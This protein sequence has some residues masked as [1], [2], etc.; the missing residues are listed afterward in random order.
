V[1]SAGSLDQWSNEDRAYR[2]RAFITYSHLDDRWARYLQTSLERFKV[3]SELPVSSKGT[4]R[5]PRR[6]GPVFR[7]REE[8]SASASIHDVVT[9]ALKA[10]AWLIVICTKHA[11]QSSWVNAAIESFKRQGK[12]QRII[13]VLVEET[14]DEPFEAYLPPAL[15]Q[16]PPLAVDVRNGREVMVT[17]IAAAMLSMPFGQLYGLERRQRARR[18]ALM[19]AALGFMM[20]A[21]VLAFVLGVA[22][23]VR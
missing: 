18:R 19:L 13:P 2:Y 21:I 1:A 9:E 4:G 7:D 3:P 22:F 8:L 5:S 12:G 14:G 10:S 15:R 20:S 11:A 6:L 16:D 17:K 23:R